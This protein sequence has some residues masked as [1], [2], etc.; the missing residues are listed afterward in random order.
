MIVILM[1]IFETTIVKL[2]R[3]F[4]YKFSFCLGSF[5]SRMNGQLYDNVDY[6]AQGFIFSDDLMYEVNY[7]TLYKWYKKTGRDKQKYRQ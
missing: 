7:G 2:W 1:F 5:I 6:S 4:Y 3:Q